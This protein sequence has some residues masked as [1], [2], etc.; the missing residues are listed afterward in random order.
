MC[1]PRIIIL[2]E[3]TLVASQPGSAL[4]RNDYAKDWVK[5]N[6][7]ALT[8]WFDLGR[9]ALWYA[10][11]AVALLLYHR[12]FTP[13]RAIRH[14]PRVP[15]FPL[16]RSYLLGESD[17]V[18]FQK[19]IMPFADEK[20]EGVV[21][22]WALGLW[23]I[24]IIDHKLFVQV[25][26][27]PHAFPKMHFP[28]D[29][30]LRRFVGTSNFLQMNGDEWKKRSIHL[31]KAFAQPLPIDLFVSLARNTFKVI[32]AAESSNSAT[33]FTVRW[34]D[35]AQ[36]FALD[37]VGASI[38]GHHFDAL[39]VRSPFVGDYNQMMHDVANPL[40]VA[41]PV[42]DRLFPR[43]EV[44]A[45]ANRLR[46]S[47]HQLIDAKRSAPA[48]DVM[49]FLLQDSEMSPAHLVDNVALLF[50]AG[51]ET[52]SGAISS[53]VYYLAVDSRAQS[54]AREE[55]LRVLGPTAD[56]SAASMTPQSL[57]Y[58][59]ACIREALRIN[60]P[61]SSTSPR[62]SQ[63][64]I[65]L[66][67]YHIP[68]GSNLICNIY[69]VHHEKSTWTDP[70]VFKPERF[71]SDGNF[72]ARHPWLPFSIGPRQCPGQKF[73]IYELRT[74][75]AML[76]RRY[77]WSLPVGSVHASRIKNGFSPFSLMS[78]QDLDITFR[79]LDGQVGL[80]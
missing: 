52:T 46:Q 60:T 6:L 4:S 40:Y 65:T 78:P 68:A 7:M 53:L 16:L 27:A 2:R 64:D 37:A 34:S 50:V 38:I 20:A 28:P 5:P 13:P 66:G 71:L 12:I 32:E 39:R 58:L 42:L 73:A 44:V 77:E 24:Y 35:V 57:P 43:R 76:L 31:Q 49:S 3:E 10:V 25:T 36:N 62:I 61:I 48:K 21:M 26:T 8:P 11:G 15:I 14:L 9:N 51:H 18:R 30:M 33:N 47:L 72:K 22:V 79:L 75:V 56:P 74:L 69:S 29:M 55:V 41:F 80:Q 45:G 23:M 70:D 17:D 19:L 67:K 63:T 1:S 54:K 59:S